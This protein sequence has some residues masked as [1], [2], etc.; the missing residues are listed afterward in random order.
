MPDCIFC[1][2]VNRQIPSG[3]VFEDDFVFA[4]LDIS[5][6]NKGH[7]LVIT[8][9]HFETFTDIPDDVIERLAVST[10]K[11]A[12]AVIESCNADGFNLLM[13]NKKVSG[14]IVPHAHFHIIPRFEND[15]HRINWEHKKYS[16]GEMASF[17]EKI[18][19]FL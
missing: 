18:K 2:I 1:R 14:Q 8:K 19:G 16:D 3:N 15:G 6:A 17:Q 11:I 13:N 7:T 5:P 12:C 9:K 10:K 4:F